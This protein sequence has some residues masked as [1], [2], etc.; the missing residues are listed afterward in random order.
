[1]HFESA[2]TGPAVVLIHAFPF[3]GRMWAGQVK[4]LSQRH[5]VIV[6]DIP[7][8]GR[9]P[10]P[11]GNPSLDD[12]ARDLVALCNA[13]GIEK[14]LVAGCSM[15][16]YI[17]FA[18]LER[19]P[20]FAAGIAFINT[21]AAADTQDARRARYEMV[22][23]ARHEGSGFLA[24]TEPPLSHQT[25]TNRPDVVALAR[26]MMA[27]ATPVGIMTAQR[28]MASRRD[29]RHML[30]EIRVPVTVIYGEDDPL[31]PRTEAQ[32]I[33]TAIP[34]AEFVPV[35]GA[36]HLPPIEQ[37]SAVSAALVAL[38][39]RCEVGSGRA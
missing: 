34:G 38:A 33:A 30:G 28:A 6:P 8:F 3:D 21:R 35:P 23:R 31:V 9:S 7:G 19:M 11:D 26:S 13:N 16:G 25:L 1:M 22:E 20:A 32:A 2:G 37:P 15:G 18:I 36:G 5:T 12:W 17:T 29:A 4:D 10:R 24:Q 14:A 27:D 39:K